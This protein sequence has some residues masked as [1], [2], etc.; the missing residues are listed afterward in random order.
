M[1]KAFYV[2][3]VYGDP[4]FSNRSWI[5]ETIRDMGTNRTDPW[6]CIGD[7]NDITNHSEKVGGRRKDQTK[8]NRF[9]A[10]MEDLGHKGHMHRHMHTWS[11]NRRGEE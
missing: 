1:G 11:N 8:I 10:F 3:W 2:T 4:D 7:F 5:W 6:M 9:R